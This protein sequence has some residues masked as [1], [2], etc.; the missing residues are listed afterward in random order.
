MGKSVLGWLMV[1][2]RSSGTRLISPQMIDFFHYRERGNERPL[3]ARTHEGAGPDGNRKT[4]SKS[5]RKRVQF[6]SVTLSCTWHLRNRLLSPQHLA[7]CVRL[8]EGWKY[9]ALR[10]ATWQRVRSST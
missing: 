1:D 7:G 8:S 6:R 3:T 4:L 10:K 5:F 2:L 9:F